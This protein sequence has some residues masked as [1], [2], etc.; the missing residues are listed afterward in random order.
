MKIVSHQFINIKIIYDNL[1]REISDVVPELHA[2]TRRD[3][4]HTNF[5]LKM[6]MFPK[7][8][9]KVPPIPF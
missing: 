5:M 7:M 9:I 4:R 2:I 1:R 8:F 3:I 6:Y